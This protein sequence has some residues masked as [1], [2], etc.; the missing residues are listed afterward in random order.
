[1]TDEPTILQEFPHHL[2]RPPIY[3]WD[4]WTDGQIRE[5][6][7]GVH[8]HSQATS[9]RTLVH[10]TAKDYGLKAKTSI[11]TY[12]DP[13]DSNETPITSVTIYFY[14]GKEET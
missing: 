9:F 3:P 8:F 1:M 13:E 12:V 6:R 2:G 14:E 5:L 11:E 10:R 7:Q 4:E